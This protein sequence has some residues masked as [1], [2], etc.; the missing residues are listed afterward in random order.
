M[1]HEPGARGVNRTM[2]QASGSPS[3]IRAAASSMDIWPPLR[4]SFSRTAGPPSQWST[5]GSM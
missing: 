2:I 5:G 1:H 3:M 4:A